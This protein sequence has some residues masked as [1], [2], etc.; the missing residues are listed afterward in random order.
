MIELLEAIASSSQVAVVRVVGVLQH[1][2]G[3]LFIVG[4]LAGL[5]M[6]RRV[7]F[8]PVETGRFRQSLQSYQL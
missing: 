5:S 7:G 2:G 4:L 6:D 3:L 8:Y 1:S